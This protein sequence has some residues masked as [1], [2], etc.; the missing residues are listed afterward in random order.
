MKKLAFLIFFLPLFTFSQEELKW[1]QL[2]DVIVETEFDEDLGME[3]T[4][5]D[6]G[7]NIS[8]WDGKEVFIEGFLIPVD[9]E[10]GLFAL[11][12][13]PYN[14]CFFCGKAGIESVIQ[15]NLK[16][17]RR[18]SGFKTDQILKFTGRLNLNAT[19]AADLIYILEDAE[20]FYG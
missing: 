15:L 1:E 12:E 4:F 3:L 20:I 13:F 19:N 9:I 2:K 16:S 18:Y 14:S 11:S 10:D 7:D 8:K 17:K 5:P 6:F